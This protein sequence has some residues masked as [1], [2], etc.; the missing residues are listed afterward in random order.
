M[1]IPREYEGSRLNMRRTAELLSMDDGHLRRLVRRRV[2]PPPRRT[3]KGLPYYDF[4]LLSVIGGVLKGGVGISGE[5]VSFYRRK[6]KKKQANRD[7]RN[8]RSRGASVDEYLRS[9]IEGCRQ[10]G[11]GAE[12][13]DASRVAAI[14]RE[15][16]GS[17]R[18]ELEQALPEVARL[19]LAGE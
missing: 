9:L 12:L 10:L 2:F 7:R 3:S 11:V 16:F 18:P 14:V 8:G 5:E 13:L 19:L 6:P 17:D 1:R 4:E 15:A